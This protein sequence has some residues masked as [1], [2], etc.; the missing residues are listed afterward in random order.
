MHEAKYLGSLKAFPGVRDC[1]GGKG[2][3]T[4]EFAK[5]ALLEAGCRVNCVN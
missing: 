2:L 1:V 4:G 5:Q 3:L